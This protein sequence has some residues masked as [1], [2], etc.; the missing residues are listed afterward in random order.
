M[1]MHVLILLLYSFPPRH[2]LVSPFWRRLLRY[3]VERCPGEP[4]ATGTASSSNNLLGSPS[5]VAV[6]SKSAFPATVWEGC[7][8]AVATGIAVREHVIMER[9]RGAE[10]GDGYGKWNEAEELGGGGAPGAGEETAWVQGDSN[11]AETGRA[12]HTPA[13]HVTNQHFQR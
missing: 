10:A 12:E 4:S 6:G 5:G 3:V 8:E 9:E 7:R 13:N 1:S 11:E 2:V